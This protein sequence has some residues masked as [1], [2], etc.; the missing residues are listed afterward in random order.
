MLSSRS[1]WTWAPLELTY[2]RGVVNGF[3]VCGSGH[4]PEQRG[5]RIRCAA[6]GH[7]IR[8]LHPVHAP[9]SLRGALRV[10]REAIPGGP[11]VDR[12]YVRTRNRARG[13]AHQHQR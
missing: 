11:P 5:E 12:E 1:E 4:L 6:L 9:L 8:I 13:G 10:S 2:A 7:V 3:P